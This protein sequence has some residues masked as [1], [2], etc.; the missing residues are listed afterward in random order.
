MN[1]VGALSRI[2]EWFQMQF[3]HWRELGSPTRPGT[4]LTRNQVALMQ[5]DNI[6]SADLLELSVTPTAVEAI[7]RKI[8]GR[9][10]V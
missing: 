1:Q 7:V 10:P 9:A 4:P 2:K 8:A 5:H 6:A 3:V